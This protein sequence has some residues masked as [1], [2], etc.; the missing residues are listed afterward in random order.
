MD[1]YTVSVLNQA[2]ASGA[3]PQQLQAKAAEMRQYKAMYE[4]PLLNSAMTF[5]EP[6]PIGMVITVISAFALSRR[7]VA[8]ASRAY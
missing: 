6:F 4:N 5:L 7:R 3:T 2:K 1:K 8:T